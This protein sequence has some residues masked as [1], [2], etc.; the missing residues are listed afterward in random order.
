MKTFYLKGEVFVF[1]DE[2]SSGYVTSI[3]KYSIIDKNWQSISDEGV[4]YQ[5]FCACGLTDKIYVLGGYVTD[6]CM[7]QADTDRCFDKKTTHGNKFPR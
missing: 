5:D 3:N 7:R 6:G 4:H 1:Y 2:D